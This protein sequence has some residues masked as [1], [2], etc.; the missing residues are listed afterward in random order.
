MALE[1]IPVGVSQCLLGETVRYDGGHKRSRYITDQLSQYF[2][3]Y[4]VCPEVAIGLGTPRKPIRLVATDKGTR[5]QQND[6]PS[7]DVTEPLADYGRKMA[8][9]LSHLCGYIFMQNSPSC[10]VYD[11]KRYGA[12]GYPKDKD[13]R[14]L[15]AQQ[16]IDKLPLLPVEEA[17]R[18]NDAGLR[19]NFITRVYAYYDWRVNVEPSPSA[20]GLI[21]FYSRYKYQVMAHHPESYKTIGRLLANL[22]SRP[23]D[24]I[25][26]DFIGE[27]MYA[28]GHKATRKGNTNALMHLRGYLKNQLDTSEKAELGDLIENYR[29]GYV[30]LVVPM[31]LLKHHL[32]KVDDPY[33]QRQSFWSPHPEKLG[34]RN[35]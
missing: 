7:I 8:G 34:L 27:F 18:L 33:L 6:D 24:D 9:E 29:L 31:T 3:Y 4:P 30:P 19:E 2:E 26:N 12:N 32:L 28:L 23:I 17:G 14:G 1:K 13:G 21:D 15:Y 10:G 25:C 5:V 35:V 20:K 11:M 22:K 16:I